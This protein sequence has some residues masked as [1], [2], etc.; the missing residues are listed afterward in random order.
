MTNIPKIQSEQDRLKS[1]IIPCYDTPE[2]RKAFFELC[3][4]TRTGLAS[5]LDNLRSKFDVDRI[6]LIEEGIPENFPLSNVMLAHVMTLYWASMILV[7]IQELHG[8][9]D[10]PVPSHYLPNDDGSNWGYVP[11]LEV[12]P[13]ILYIAKSIPYF[14]QPDAGSICPQSFSFPLGCALNI[15]SYTN[16]SQIPEYRRLLKAFSKGPIGL[17][18]Q[19]FL[20]SLQ[21]LSDPEARAPEDDSESE[22]ALLQAKYEDIRRNATKFHEE[23]M[24][25]QRPL[26]Q[27][28]AIWRE[29]SV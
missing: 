14:F 25:I 3:Q 22:E 17:Q 20:T 4:A 28:G 15:A 11:N 16:A 13:Y 27:D 1:G 7:N 24:L 5:W 2:R 26:A 12:M 10:F 29:K 8:L 23:G 6:T 21:V 18:I 19:K 9:R